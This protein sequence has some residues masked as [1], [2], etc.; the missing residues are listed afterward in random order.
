MCS[1]TIK[2]SALAAVWACLRVGRTG[3]ALLAIAVALDVSRSEL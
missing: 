1:P 3:L 2:G